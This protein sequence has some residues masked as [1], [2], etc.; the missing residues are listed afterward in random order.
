[1]VLAWTL[2]PGIAASHYEER[3]RA[4]TPSAIELER[5]VR[6][7]AGQTAGGSELW[8][9]FEIL[10]HPLAVFDGSGTYLFR[11]PSPPEVFDA[12]SEENLDFHVKSGRHEA[13]FADS[14]AEIGDAVVATVLIDRPEEGRSPTDLAA[15]AIHEAFHAHQQLN[16]PGWVAN[17]AAQFT[18]PATDA[19][20]L[21]LHYQEAEAFRRANSAHGAGAARCWTRTALA[22]RD[23]RM[24]HMDPDHAQYEHG[25]E[26]LEGLAHYVERRAAGRRPDTL[27]GIRFHAAQIRRR[28]YELGVAQAALLDRFDSQWKHEL[29]RDDQQ[30]LGTMLAEAVGAG[31]RCALDEQTLLAIESRAEQAVEQLVM[32]LDDTLD[33]FRSRGGW[34]V[35]ITTD[36]DRLLFPVQIDP[37]NV[38]ILGGL[39]TLHTRAVRLRN[40]HGHLDVTDETTLTKGAG[41][42][43]LFDGVQR[44]E[45][46]GLPEPSVEEDYNGIRVHAG[47]LNLRFSDA[48]LSRSANSILISLEP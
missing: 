5:E 8:P 17:V 47:G 9:G 6:R 46:T 7:I 19:R 45:L 38:E 20:L 39:K 48:T 24:S 18:Y 21:A 36:E 25:M 15:A 32:S 26:W 11:H 2:G 16:H 3:A 27:A 41:A 29:A 42:H 37:V 30:Q 13:V 31:E 10:S 4:S 34:R 35:V 33:T 43:P 12:A 22:I 1:M 14:I 44:V 28:T 40:S 23:D